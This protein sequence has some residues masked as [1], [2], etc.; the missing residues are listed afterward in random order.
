MPG[1]NLS[2]KNKA[3]SKIIET[4]KGKANEEGLKKSNGHIIVELVEYI[5]N[6]ILCKTILKKATGHI[7]FSSFDTDYG[8]KYP[9]TKY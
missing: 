6:S 4:L 1:N 7:T 2:T 3:V 8:V 9:Q 5:A